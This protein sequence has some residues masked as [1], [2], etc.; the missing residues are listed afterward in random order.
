MNLDVCHAGTFLKNIF[1]D[2]KQ[3]VKILFW[4]V[5]REVL[6]S[7]FL[8]ILRIYLNSFFSLFSDLHLPS[9]QLV[10][11]S[12]ETWGICSDLMN[13]FCCDPNVLY[14]E[15]IFC[16]LKQDKDFKSLCYKINHSKYFESSRETISTEDD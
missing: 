16:S 14:V 13:D 7:K 2:N 15:K 4:F 8:S 9:C 10:F 5:V 11:P 1:R 12:Q 6:F 3:V